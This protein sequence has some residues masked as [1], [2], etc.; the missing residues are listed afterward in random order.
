MHG[1]AGLRILVVSRLLAK[2]DEFAAPH[3][4][5]PDRQYV[6]SAFEKVGDFGIFPTRYR[7]LQHIGWSLAKNP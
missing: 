4:M 1:L 2:Q 5:Q 7:I 3:P 6:A